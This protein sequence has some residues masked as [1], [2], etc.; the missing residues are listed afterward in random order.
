MPLSVPTEGG[1]RQRSDDAPLGRGD[2]LRA[3]GDILDVRQRAGDGGATHCH[4]F[5]EYSVRSPGSKTRT[6]KQPIWRQSYGVLNGCW[7]RSGDKAMAVVAEKAVRVE[8]AAI[9]VEPKVATRPFE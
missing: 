5:L 2:R 6:T 4:W 7:R 9:H 3:S 8:V 1:Q